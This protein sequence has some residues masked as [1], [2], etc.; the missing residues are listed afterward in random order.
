LSRKL[1]PPAVPLLKVAWPG[2]VTVLV[3]AAALALT[4]LLPAAVLP[5]DGSGEA[6][7]LLLLL[8]LLLIHLDT[9]AGWWLGLAHLLLA[10][11]LVA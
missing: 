5:G 1:L 8:G 6:W 3:I 9:T 4:L 2:A 11:E 10:A 7:R